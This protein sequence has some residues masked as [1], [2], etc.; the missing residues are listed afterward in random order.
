M[1]GSSS[2]APHADDREKPAL[3]LTLAPDSHLPNGKVQVVT[4]DSKPEGDQF[5]IDNIFVLQPIA[6]TLVADNPDDEITLIIGKDRW[7]ETLRTQ[8]TGPGKKSVTEKFRTQGEVRMTVK[9]EGPPKP[10]HLV[11]WVGD[12]VQP[13]LAPVITSM[14]TYNGPNKS[15]G[16]GDSSTK[17]ALIAIGILVG[18]IFIIVI[19]V[20]RR[21]R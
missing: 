7:D 5:F 19:A 4:S 14:K 1:A 10:Y 15:G 13:Q 12:E 9:A 8:K 3:E 20:K 6:I 18:V 16:G 21:K 17:N 2:A 11:A